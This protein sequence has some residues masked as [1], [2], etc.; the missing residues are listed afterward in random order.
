M[1]RVSGVVTMKNS[2]SVLNRKAFNKGISCLLSFVLMTNI[3]TSLLSRRVLAAA[4]NIEFSNNTVTLSP[5][6]YSEPDNFY[7]MSDSDGT[8]FISTSY[9]NPVAEIT[10]PDNCSFDIDSSCVLKCYTSYNFDSITLEPGGTT[11]TS[12]LDLYGS[13]NVYTWNSIEGN[14]NCRVN[15]YATLKF[16]TFN[17][18]DIESNMGS[19]FSLIN[20]A[21]G[22]IVADYVTIDGYDFNDYQDAEIHVTYSLSYTTHLPLKSTVYAQ[23]NTTIY[24]SGESYQDDIT[25]KVGN[26]TKVLS[27]AI[28]N[29]T[30][31]DLFDNPN[32]SLGTIPT[33]VYYGQDYEPGFMNLVSV[34]DG[35]DK[36]KVYFE[37]SKPVGTLLSDKPTAKG[38]GYYVRA[39]APSY[40]TYLEA[41]SEWKQF[42]IDYLSES[43]LG[44][45]APYFTVSGIVNGKYV[46][47]DL[48]LTTTTGILAGS[49]YTGDGTYSNSLTLDSS[50]LFRDGP[51]NTDYEIALRRSSDDATTAGYSF[52]YWY[53]AAS[54]L[55][56]DPYDPYVDVETADGVET[57]I[58]DGILTG[59]EVVIGVG[60]ENLDKIY[61]NGELYDYGEAEE[62]YVDIE[63]NSV[64]GKTTDYTIKATDLAGRSTT[65]EFT[66]F[67][68]TTEPLLTVSVPA[69]VYAGDNYDVTVKTN[70]DGEVSYRYFDVNSDTPLA[71]KPTTPG[72]YV[73]S[74][75]VSETALYYGT[76]DSAE[77]TIVKR[78]PTAEIYVPDSNIGES[79]SPV[80]TTDSDGKDE[81]VIEYKPI[82]TDDRFYSTTKPAVIGAYDVRVT[83]P[84]TAKYN[85]AV[86]TSEFTIKKKVP[87][88]VLNI[89]SPYVGTD[90][91]PSVTTNS[92]GA[93]KVVIEYKAKDASDDTYTTTVPTT[94]GTY[95]VRA[96]VPETATFASVSATTE[97]TLR[98]LEAPANA[99]EMTGTTGKNGYY[100]SGV[101][102]KAPAGYL[103]SG[104]Y[105]GTY[106][107]SITYTDSLTSVY[108]KRTSDN[109]LTSAITVSKPKIDTQA[110]SFKAGTGNVVSGSVM[111]VSNLNLTVDDPNLKS[112][113]VN[114][115]PIN[116]TA[117]KD[118]VLTL[119]PGFGTKTFKI[120]AEDEAGNVS[121]IEFTLKAEWLESKT[122]IPDVVLPLE[123]N[124][125][126]NL[127]E[128]Y[129]IV[130]RNTPEGPVKDNTVY[131]GGMPFYVEE[132]GDY[133]FTKVT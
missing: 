7:L 1:E 70:S 108:L 56:Y 76:G 28:N 104:I 117:D 36:S 92:D 96:T 22:K 69:T 15:N 107:E 21:G 81:A 75:S 89:G 29:E 79:Y 30:A 116:L 87:A 20:A 43:D 46:T 100:V 67:P 83:I 25:L 3:G 115:E 121:N 130:T 50:L 12:A 37:Y 18:G 119:S 27:G 53:P 88:F 40:G 99:F 90:Y 102:L 48:V 82:G 123:S 24:K 52:T 101:E 66:L 31:G 33:T 71:G 128:G 6:S 13:E 133:T 61:I 62:G 68:N 78:T 54:E 34:A 127:G 118:N 74:V 59:D 112:L 129:W 58:E 109:A 17:M 124:E 60:D 63:L 35:Y 47:G 86:A 120:T 64:A 2:G 42:S 10:I 105:G 55:I 113:K 85:A 91:K 45:S 26:A 39:V 80:V 132:G 98:Y 125:Y 32:V 73:V 95:V 8:I 84:E 11:T 44:V 131:S 93:A 111:Y 19:A 16:D 126:Y 49:G 5:V 103:I 23:E 14:G 114:G 106:T 110:P 9:D 51:L 72:K 65:L 57:S 122:I 38:S 94:Y 77:Y 4:D 41:K 97:F